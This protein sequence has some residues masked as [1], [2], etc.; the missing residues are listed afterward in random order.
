M[1]LASELLA[2]WASVMRTVELRS[3]MHGRFEVS[4]DGEM[5]FSKAALKRFPRP[6]EMVRTF[7]R[8]LGPPLEWRASRDQ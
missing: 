2:H 6:G 4:L 8:H 3:G 7:E 5:T 1:S